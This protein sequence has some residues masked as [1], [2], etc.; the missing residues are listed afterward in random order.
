MSLHLYFMIISLVLVHNLCH[1]TSVLRHNLCHWTYAL[2][3]S[4]LTELM[5]YEFSFIL[6]YFLFLA[7]RCIF[8]YFLLLKMPKDKI[9]KINNFKGKKLKITKNRGTCAK[10]YQ[11]SWLFHVFFVI[12]YYPFVRRRSIVF[13]LW[14]LEQFF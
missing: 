13:S 2:A 3:Q 5:P 11:D 1:W 7:I 14:V 10:S 6:H 8:D 4:T 9:V 12:Q